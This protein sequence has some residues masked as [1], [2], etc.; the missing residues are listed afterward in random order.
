VDEK[1]CHYGP[2]HCCLG[3][4]AFSQEAPGNYLHSDADI[5]AA[6][7]LKVGGALVAL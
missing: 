7:E 1:I 5:S 3:L 6:M 4:A 2:C